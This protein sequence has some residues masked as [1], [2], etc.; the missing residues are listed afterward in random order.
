MSNLKNKILNYVK[1]RMKNDIFSPK[2]LV[3]LLL[4]YIR[5]VK[6][7]SSKVKVVISTKRKL[8]AADMMI[9]YYV[10]FYLMYRVFSFV[11]AFIQL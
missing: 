5:L 11:C 3:N 2:K 4:H 6:Q 9:F 1:R 8:N 10:K 7:I